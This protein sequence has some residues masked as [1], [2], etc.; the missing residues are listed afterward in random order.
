[1][2]A[3]PERQDPMEAYESVARAS[4]DLL[5]AARAGDWER[6]DRQQARCHAQVELARHVLPRTLSAAESRRRREILMGILADDREIRD[7]LEP[8]TR[9]LESILH[10]RGAPG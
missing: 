4:R 7:I 9:R 3:G 5:D 6:F 10:L 1:M 8:V 2:N